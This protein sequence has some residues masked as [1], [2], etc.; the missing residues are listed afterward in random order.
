MYPRVKNEIRMQAQSFQS[1][2]FLYGF[3]GIFKKGGGEEHS[4]MKM[5]HPTLAPNFWV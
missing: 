5:P 3:L 2:Y 4:Q 1:A